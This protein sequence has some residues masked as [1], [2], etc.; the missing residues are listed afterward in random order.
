M[1]ESK[2]ICEMRCK[3]R[4]KLWNGG[5]EFEK[6]LTRTRIERVKVANQNWNWNNWTKLEMFNSMN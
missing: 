5:E 2:Y 6:E 3:F 1:I 4:T